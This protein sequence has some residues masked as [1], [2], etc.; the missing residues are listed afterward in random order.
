M[1]CSS[2]PGYH[3]FIPNFVSYDSY[4]VSKERLPWTFDA[5]L[6]VA[7]KIKSGNKLPAPSFFRTLAGAQGIA[8]DETVL[9]IGFVKYSKLGQARLNNQYHPWDLFLPPVWRNAHRE[10]DASVFGP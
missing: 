7:G 8:K 10:C 4:E 1:P 5:V 6:T 2:F 3:F 9:R